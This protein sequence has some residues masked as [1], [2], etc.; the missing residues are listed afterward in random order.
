MRKP[1]MV[2]GTQIGRVSSQI[3]FFI[4]FVSHIVT[5]MQCNKVLILATSCEHE[6]MHMH[7]RQI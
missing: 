3:V 7:A 6:Q 1:M 2:S 5:A 4:H